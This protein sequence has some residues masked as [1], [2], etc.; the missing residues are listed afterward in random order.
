MCK[1]GG[2]V[3]RAVEG[4]PIMT[5]QMRRT[6]QEVEIIRQEDTVDVKV[7]SSHLSSNS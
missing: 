2:A 4:A 3:A 6:V 5:K 1:G 7:S